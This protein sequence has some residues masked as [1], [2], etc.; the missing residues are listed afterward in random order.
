MR[1]L[2]IGILACL[3]MGNRGCQT[4]TVVLPEGPI[5]AELG[6]AKDEQIKGLLA[7]VKAEM[8]ARELER[9]QAALA[10]ANLVGVEFAVEH[11]EAGLPRNAIEEE[12]KLGRARLPEPNPVEVIKAKDRVI[13]IL[14]N[15]V[16]KAK[17]MY[18]QA[19]DEAK[20]A[21][22]QIAAKDKEIAERD[23]KIGAGEETIIKLTADAKAEKLAHLKDV[24]DTIS[25]LEKERDE[26]EQKSLMF[27]LGIGA[28]ALIIGGIVLIAA[29]SGRLV[30]QGSILSVGGG[31][32]ILL[33]LGYI[34][35][36]SQPWFPVVAGIVA[37]II[38][39]TIIWA[40][41]R[42]WVNH[43]LDKKKTQAIQD[44]RD[45][46]AAKGDT[47]AIDTLDEHLEYR[48][49]KDGSFWQKAQLK[50]EVDL[51]LIDPKGEAALVQVAPD[52]T[53]KS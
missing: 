29:T 30:I 32:V 11:V 9:A 35:L 52:S 37:A 23:A 7:Q 44:M 31:L 53:P 18:G 34:S 36:V 8:D 41:W 16:E 33:R 45:E 10:A 38:L 1:L 25:R 40:V 49:G 42:M 5:S 14:Q 19:F 12:A 13:A 43:E 24:Q 15:E 21:K 28:V 20:Q 4:S 48:M 6:K 2:G 47:K 22:A 50:T 46:A 3:M 17:M 39:G 26:A 51:G 27:W